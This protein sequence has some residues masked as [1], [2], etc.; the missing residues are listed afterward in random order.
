MDSDKAEIAES[1]QIRPG[2]PTRAVNFH[3]LV[4]KNK[5]LG[6]GPELY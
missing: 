2:F 1:T 6:K 3:L 5:N 4:G